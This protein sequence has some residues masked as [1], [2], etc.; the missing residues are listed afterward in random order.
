MIISKSKAEQLEKMMIDFAR[1]YNLL[2][3]ADL[4]CSKDNQEY[5]EFK[6]IRLFDKEKRY[7]FYWEHSDSLSAGAAAIFADV[8]NYFE[9][10]KTP[11]EQ[12][13]FFDIKDVIFHD[14]AT[15]VKWA[16]GTK[17][18]VKTQNGEEYDP[19]KGLAM[20]IAKKAL[21][22]EGNYYNTI[23]KWVSKYDPPMT[24]PYIPPITLKFDVA[25]FYKNV[26]EW[27]RKLLGIEDD[28]ISDVNESIENTFMKDSLD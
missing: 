15:I 4:Y 26:E 8:I 13:N 27:R 28:V 3:V 16:D 17:T 10:Y 5:S 25:K 18:V 6:F 7:F 22:N 11:G 14:P 23:K 21:G 24:Y 9:L 1:K 20:A 2:V 19:E 12:R